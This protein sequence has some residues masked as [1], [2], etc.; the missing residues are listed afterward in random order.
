[1]N[2]DD[3]WWYC[4]Y[5]IYIYTYTYVFFR[6][7]PEW[8]RMGWIIVFLWNQWRKSL[9]SG[10]LK[11]SF[12][13]H[14]KGKRGGVVRMVRRQ[15]WGCSDVFQFGLCAACSSATKF[16]KIE[17][18]F[19]QMSSIP[20]WRQQSLSNKARSP[21]WEAFQGRQLFWSLA[22]AKFAGVKFWYF[23]ILIF[24]K[25]WGCFYQTVCN[26]VN[27]CQ[28]WFGQSKDPARSEFQ[29][30]RELMRACKKS[31]LQLG[32]MRAFAGT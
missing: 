3:I 8:S 25:F 6:F 18:W 22:F 2:T 29:N 13:K 23:V 1:M 15:T 28:L 26:T 17:T 21:S 27:G 10:I 14:T 4:I 9:E 7:L 24:W 31:V 16:V 30:P 32:A 5:Y 12:Y 20:G 11:G 19:V